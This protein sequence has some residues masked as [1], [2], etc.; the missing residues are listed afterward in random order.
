MLMPGV[1]E[2]QMAW[3]VA[4][5]CFR[6][7]RVNLRMQ[8]SETELLS[9]DSKLLHQKMKEMDIWWQENDAACVFGCMRVD[10]CSCFSVLYELEMDA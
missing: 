2:R 10:G 7:L 4:Y 3:Q 8:L 5:C 6:D 9:E 1:D